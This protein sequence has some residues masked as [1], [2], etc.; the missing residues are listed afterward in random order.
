[1]DLW[2][3]VDMD[4]IEAVVTAVER[5][6]ASLTAEA[7]GVQEA[8]RQLNVKVMRH[9]LREKGI[10]IGDRVIIDYESGPSECILEG[11]EPHWRGLDVRMVTRAF[12]KRG[13]PRKQADLYDGNVGF[14][15]R[16]DDSS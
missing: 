2:L 8:I 15:T 6:L 5:R 1:M 9:E 3:D 12:T 13:K 7:L 16:V 4:Q 11:I 14:V 10:R